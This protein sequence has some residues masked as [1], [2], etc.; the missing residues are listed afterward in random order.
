MITG[1]VVMLGAA[2]RYIAVIGEI[3][4]LMRV[5]VT[6]GSCHYAWTNRM[7]CCRKWSWYRFSQSS[8]RVHC[9]VIRF[10]G[11]L[12]PLRM[13]TSVGQI[14]IVQSPACCSV[15]CL[16]KIARVTSKNSTCFSGLWSF[17]GMKF[18]TAG[19]A[20]TSR[21]LLLPSHTSHPS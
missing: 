19:G 15:L 7:T 12:F 6:A 2:P 3:A 21:H 10:R 8:W 9:N 16:S 13:L 14:L 11:I 4:G 5:G 18:Q 20:Y 17:S 1:L